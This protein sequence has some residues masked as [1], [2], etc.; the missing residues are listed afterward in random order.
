[1]TNQK[2]ASFERLAA[3]YLAAVLDDDAVD[4][5]VHT[6]KN[7][8]GD[9]RGVKAHGQ[10]VAVECKNTVRL[11]LAGWVGEAEV[12]RVNLQAL[13]GLTI[14]KRAGKGKAQMGQQY[15]TMTLDDLAALLTGRRP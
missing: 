7:D 8:K 3:D 6:G 2:G 12:E 9:I 13:V 1:M 10:R 11:N 4:R 5:Q 14:H 15:V